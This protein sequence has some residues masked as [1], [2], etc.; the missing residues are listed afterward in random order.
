MDEKKLRVATF[1][2]ALTTL[3]L[4]GIVAV[5]NL[6][7]YRRVERLETTHGLQAMPQ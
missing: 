3:V 6:H 1:W 7:L 4:I 2:L 5:G